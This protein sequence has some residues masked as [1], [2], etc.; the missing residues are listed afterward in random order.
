MISLSLATLHSIF[1]TFRHND[2]HASNVLVQCVDPVEIRRSL[3]TRLPAT[4]PLLVEYELSG[5]R[6]QIDLERA[7]FRCL[8]WDFSFASIEERDGGRVGLD[9]VAPREV[10]FGS[11]VQ[12]SKTA[13]NQYCDIFKI[14]D[15]LRWVMTQGEGKG[16]QALS[17]L[18][19]QQIDSVAPMDLSYVGEEPSFDQKKQRQLR[20]HSELQHTSPTQVLL[21]DDMFADLRVDEIPSKNRLRPVYSIHS[22]GDGPLDPNRLM[23]WPILHTPGKFL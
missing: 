17:G 14:C 11:V 5:R 21:Y 6:W 19:R 16:W 3:G 22:R 20:I 1:P 2:L 12:L 7:P 23:M 18:S 15:T 9:C 10:R 4:H 8:L 13:P